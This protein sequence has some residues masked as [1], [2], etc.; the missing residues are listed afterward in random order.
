ME[1][2]TSVFTTTQEYAAEAVKTLL[3][4]AGIAAVILN[5]K[6]SAYVWMGEINVMVSNEEVE[7][8]SGILEAN[9]SG[10]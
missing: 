1:N 3:E 4:R 5:Q 7:R 6:D 8:A 9:K 10:E 2:W